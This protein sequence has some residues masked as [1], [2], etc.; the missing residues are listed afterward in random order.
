ME[1]YKNMNDDA[2]L[3]AQDVPAWFPVCINKECPRC[4]EC[5]RYRC[6][7]VLSPENETVFCVSPSQWESDGCRHF[8][9][10][11]PIRMARGFTK[12]F[13]QVLT[14]HAASLRLDLTALL[15][16]V[17]IYYEYKRG[18]RLL[19]PDEQAEI[20]RIV[21]HYGY[22]WEVSFDGYVDCLRFPETLSAKVF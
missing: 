2:T 1:A 11:Q 17:R 8:V 21:R 5:L 15:H 7:Q 20:R 10:G 3:K 6:A 14:K 22:E 12:L 4:G 9:D 18:K 16:G 19:T 13:D